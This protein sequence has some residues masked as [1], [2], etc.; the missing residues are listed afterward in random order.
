[1]PLSSTLH[2]QPH[3]VSPESILSS[4][5]SRLSQASQSPSSAST[6]TRNDSN[7]S[8]EFSSS[9]SSSTGSSSCPTSRH[10]TPDLSIIS[11][12]STRDIQDLH[13]QDAVA[14]DHTSFTCTICHIQSILCL[15]LSTC[16]L[17]PHEVS[18]C[19]QV[20]LVVELFKEND[21]LHF[22]QNLRVNPHTF[23]FL[24]ML[25]ENNTIFHNNLNAPQLPVSYQLAIALYQFGHYGIASS[26][27]KVAQ[28]AGC[29]AG[30][31]VKAT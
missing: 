14:Y 27:V 30:T 24:L 5:A 4:L 6:S 26:A 23:E 25:I 21:P 1:M 16:V 15:L 31:V 3:P 2:C 18:K 28:W 11:T 29:S 8:L 22:C 10:S 17:A 7:S 13:Q 12:P 20:G 9:S 19:S